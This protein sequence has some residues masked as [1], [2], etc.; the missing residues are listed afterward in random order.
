M[1]KK[2]W[3]TW[4][5]K[6][7][8]MYVKSGSWVFNEKLNDITCKAAEPNCCPLLTSLLPSY[9]LCAFSSSCSIFLGPQNSLL[10]QILASYLWGHLQISLGCYYMNNQLSHLRNS[11]CSTSLNVDSCCC[12]DRSLYRNLLGELSLMLTVGLCCGTKE[13]TGASMRWFEFI[14]F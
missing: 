12:Y 14:I 6:Y 2:G 11:L 4:G 1:E 7:V 10:G 9:C 3:W 5:C 13:R 8:M